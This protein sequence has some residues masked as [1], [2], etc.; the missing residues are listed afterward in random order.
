MWELLEE[1]LTFLNV[2]EEIE[3]YNHRSDLKREV[4]L[5]KREQVRKLRKDRKER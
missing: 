3:D 1:V 5:A 4:H 2:I